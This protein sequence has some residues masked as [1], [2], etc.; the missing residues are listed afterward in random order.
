MV[1]NTAGNIRYF[2]FTTNELLGK[3]PLIIAGK[4]GTT[5]LAGEV[6]ISVVKYQGRLILI[7]VI[8]ST[9]RYADTQILLNWL[10]Y[11][12]AWQ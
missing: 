12:L 4:T 10:Q 2:L 1:Y 9:D 7:I 3:N 8:G 6:L 5:D 11:N